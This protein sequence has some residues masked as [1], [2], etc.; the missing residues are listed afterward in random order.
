MPSSPVAMAAQSAPTPAPLITQ[1]TSLAHL[2]ALPSILHPLSPSLAA[3]HLSRL[4]LLAALPQAATDPI[5]CPACG[6]LEVPGWTSSLAVG[7]GTDKKK[8]KGGGGRPAKKKPFN[9]V[10]KMCL[11][12]GE[13]RFER[14]STR[15]RLNEFPSARRTR[16][17]AKEAEAAT[18]ALAAATAATSAA[19]SPNGG[20]SFKLQ[21]LPTPS[22]FSSSA[23]SSRSDTPTAL[24][25]PSLAH[26][27]TS[28]PTPPAM[29]MPLPS[30]ATSSARASPEPGAMA[31]KPG[32]EKKKKSGLQK[33]LALN[34]EKEEEEARKKKA[35][36]SS[37]LD[38]M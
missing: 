9:A 22:S 28:H 25:S 23:L 1:P 2:L 20:D 5:C 10:R 4:R 13:R 7:R 11:V 15:A 35:A 19:A 32:R 16:A 14:G 26:V 27:P 33:M 3:L 18:A 34:K 17:K 21:M 24:A 8:T 38:W 30:S 29:P 36:S 37:L 6:A 31:K 12:C